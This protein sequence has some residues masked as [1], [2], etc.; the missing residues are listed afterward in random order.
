[1][2]SFMATVLLDARG[3][4]GKRTGRC[5]MMRDVGGQK[6]RQKALS[7]RRDGAE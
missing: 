5:T 2:S 6:G 7:T 1:M 4:G 3:E